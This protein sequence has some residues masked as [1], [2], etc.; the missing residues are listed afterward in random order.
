MYAKGLNR[1][2]DKICGNTSCPTYWHHQT[3][4]K[5]NLCSVAI[6]FVQEKSPDWWNGI[7]VPPLSES[8]KAAYH[9]SSYFQLGSTLLSSR[10]STVPGLW[11]SIHDEL[12]GSGQDTVS[13][14]LDPTQDLARPHALHHL[15]QEVGRRPSHCHV[16]VAATERPQSMHFTLSLSSFSNNN[17]LKNQPPS[18]SPKM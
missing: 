8:S 15:H 2:A 18:I 11:W 6:S 17:V 13:D 4:R 14:I 5:K 9:K 7:F 10:S 3:D 12:C 1:R 16:L